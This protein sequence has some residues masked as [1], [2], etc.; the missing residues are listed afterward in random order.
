MLRYVGIL[1]IGLITFNAG[2]E[3]KAQ[4]GGSAVPF[5]LIGTDARAGGMGGV[6]TALTDDINAI[7]WNPGGLGFLDYFEAPYGFDEDVEA[8]PFRQVA[9][10]FSPWL[11]QFNADLYYSNL[12]VGQYVESLGGTV[13][14]NFTL[15]NLGEF[16]R[17]LENGQQRGTFI[18]NEFAVGLSYGTIIAPDLG[19]GV[20]VKYIQ[21][22]LTPTST[23]GQQAGAGIS[24]AFDLG[25]LWR[26]TD[27]WVFE[28]RLGLGI[29]I[30]NV[31][32]RITYIQ[33]ADPL[34]TNLRLGA[35]YRAYE[36][37]FN[38]LTIAA[39]FGK[40]LVR[41]D[42]SGSDPIPLSFVTAWD[43]SGAEFSIGTEYWYQQVIAFRLGYFT[44]PASIGNR[45]FYNLGVGFRYD[46]FKL[47]FGYIVTVEDNH[48]L[49]NTMRFS[50]LVDWE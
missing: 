48:P 28:D 23:S 11:P 35:S 10:S 43:N 19:A 30:Q 27:F 33:E 37:E 21:S 18:S 25:V 1:L 4:A 49:A 42:S 8:S 20:N 31:G 9:V 41:R 6:G 3:L 32:P 2:S 15:M 12:N 45:Q 50:L 47:D 22:N 34:P 44:E 29:N 40:V 16:R 38:D 24:V 26:P 17:T 14:F 39:D 5:L 36:D 46:I 7:Y 13:A